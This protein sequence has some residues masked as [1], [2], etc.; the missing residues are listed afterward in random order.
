MLIA[1]RADRREHVRLRH[2]AD[3]TVDRQHQNDPRPDAGRR[4]QRKAVR[5]ERHLHAFESADD[6][7]AERNQHERQHDDEKSLHDV[8]PR[9]RHDTADEAVQDE[10]HRHRDNDLIRAGSGTGRLADHLAGAFE[11]Y[12]DPDDEEGDREHDVDGAHERAVPILGELRHRRA[13]DATKHRRH[14]PVERRDE[15]VLPLEPDCGR[16]RRIHRARE[17]HRHLR[18][19]PDAEALAHHHP[20]TE[21]SLAQKVFAGVTYPVADVETDAGD[22]DEVYDEHEPIE[23]RNGHGATLII[24]ADAVAADRQDAGRDAL[25]AG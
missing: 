10:H 1:P 23:R 4:R 7:P 8:G 2:D 17:R 16:A 19:R 6:A 12:A 22:D 20:R 5:L 13:P 15:Q 14:D 18:V 21:S 9:P 25:C 11:Q 3:Q 24:G